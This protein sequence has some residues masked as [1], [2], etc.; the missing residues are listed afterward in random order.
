MDAMTL[1]IKI[2]LPVI[3]SSDKYK[4]WLAL[5]WVQIQID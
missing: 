1:K 3:F 2:K 5:N 4:V